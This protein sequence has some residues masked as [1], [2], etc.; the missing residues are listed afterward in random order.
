MTP[1]KAAGQLATVL[2]AIATPP[3]ARSTKLRYFAV[4]ND[5]ASTEA[6][7]VYYFDGTTN[8]QIG[9]CT[10]LPDEWAE[11]FDGS[12]EIDLGIGESIKGLTTNATSVNYVILGESS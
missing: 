6:V 1:F 9:A 10:L 3:T 8:R 7:A 5:G 12:V 4:F 2:G 11:V